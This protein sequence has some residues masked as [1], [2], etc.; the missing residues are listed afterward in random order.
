MPQ[1]D[2]SRSQS[3]LP[4]QFATWFDTQAASLRGRVLAW[5]GAILALIGL[6]DAATSLLT[7]SQS[8]TCSVGISFPW[9]QPSGPSETWSDEVGG[10]GGAVFSPITCRPDEVLVGLYGKTGNG[11]IVFSMGPVCAAARFDRGR[12]VASLSSDV[13]KGDQVGSNQGNPFELACPSN[14]VVVGSDLE[15][16]VVDTNA[17]PHEYLVLPLNL[18]CSNALTA[19]NGLRNSISSTG[20]RLPTA[21]RKPF[22]CP[23]GNA[24]FG[25]KGRAGQFVDAISL[26]CRRK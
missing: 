25:I 8:I 22:A 19:N 18:R 24:A 21:S 12:R 13:R 17:G 15:A 11:P 2:T 6:I 3:G 10:P 26:G 4:G 16:A 14:T 7:K 1:D 9:C 23:D 5:T 20:D